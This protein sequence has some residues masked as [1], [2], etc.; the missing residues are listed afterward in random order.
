MVA[1]PRNHMGKVGNE[2]RNPKKVP[3][4]C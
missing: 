2:F 4:N 3:E 1:D